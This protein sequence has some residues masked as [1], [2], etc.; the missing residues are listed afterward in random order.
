MFCVALVGHVCLCMHHFQSEAIE[1]LKQL[2]KR[3]FNTGLVL[4]LVAR[5]HFE[6][7]QY[8]QVS[9]DWWQGGGQIFYS[10]NFCSLHS[11][12]EWVELIS[13]VAPCVHTVCGRVCAGASIRTVAR[14]GHGVLFHR[15]LAF[16]ARHGMVFFFLRSV[17]VCV[18]HAFTLD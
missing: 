12:L 17:H 14:R 5:C 1:C 9:N 3:H 18:A 4:T 8:T 7:T 13:C 16:A 11:E 10:E 6:M 15:A 2:S